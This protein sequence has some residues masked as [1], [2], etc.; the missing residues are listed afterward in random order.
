M[1]N[2]ETIKNFY[3]KGLWNENLVMMAVKKGIITSEEAAQ[4]IASK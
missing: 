1:L 4:I 3:L 2:F